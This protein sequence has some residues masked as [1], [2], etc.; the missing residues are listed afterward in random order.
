MCKENSRLLIFWKRTDKHPQDVCRRRPLELH[1]RPHGFVLITSAGD[2]LKTPL[3]DDPWRLYR[4]IWGRLQDVTMERLEDVIFQSPEHVGRGH[5]L[6]VCRG[7]Y[8]PLYRGPDG[9]VHRTY[10]RK[11]FRIS[12]GR[13]FP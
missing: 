12:S 2:L 7:I 5:P 1:I 3:G 4:T 8:F 10:F 9:Y 11:V 6:D 13:N